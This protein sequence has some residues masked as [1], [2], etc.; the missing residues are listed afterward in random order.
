MLTSRVH[1]VNLASS[2]NKAWACSFLTQT[3]DTLAPS[4]PFHGRHAIQRGILSA[5]GVT[6]NMTLDGFPLPK[7]GSSRPMFRQDVRNSMPYRTS[8][9]SCCCGSASLQLVAAAGYSVPLEPVRYL[10]LGVPD[11]LDQIE[12]VP[13]CHRAASSHDHLPD[14]AVAVVSVLGTHI[15]AQIGFQGEHGGGLRVGHDRASAAPP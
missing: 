14:G 2:R 3:V 8:R 5:I 11:H 4:I 1:H 6:W 13:V 15:P 12:D 9:S 7:S 10:V